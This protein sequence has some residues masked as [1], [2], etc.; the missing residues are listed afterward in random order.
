MAEENK[1]QQYRVTHIKA[2]PTL[3]VILKT[4]CVYICM[5]AQLHI[6]MKFNKESPSPR[7]K[8]IYW[9]QGLVL[10]MK[11]LMPWI[12]KK[13][14]NCDIFSCLHARY[15]F[16]LSSRNMSASRTNLVLQFNFSWWCQMLS[17]SNLIFNY[18]VI[19]QANLFCIILKQIC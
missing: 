9:K 5:S 14:L 11:S 3:K 10:Y 4:R 2:P 16:F 8:I 17:L 7:R 18:V 1:V 19:H 15:E 13:M 12:P 6:P